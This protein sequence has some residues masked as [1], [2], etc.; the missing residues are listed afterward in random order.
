MRQYL[1]LFRINRRVFFKLGAQRKY[2]CR[3]CVRA[4]RI[5]VYMY[6]CECLVNNGVFIYLFIF[7]RAI[8]YGVSELAQLEEACNENLCSPGFVAE[9]TEDNLR[10]GSIIKTRVHSIHV[11]LDQHNHWEISKSSKK[12]YATRRIRTTCA[13]HILLLAI[14]RAVTYTRRG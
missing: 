11:S 5:Y 1:P 4:L 8:N 13:C 14:P 3:I 12:A 6:T 10:V 9:R 2:S 7:S